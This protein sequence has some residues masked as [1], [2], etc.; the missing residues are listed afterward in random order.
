MCDFTE[1]DVVVTR[2]LQLICRHEPNLN[3]TTD[4][5]Q[6]FPHHAATYIIDGETISGIFACDLTLAEIKQLRAKQRWA[7]RDHTHDGAFAVATLSEFLDV[8]LSASRAVGIYPEV[9]HPTW[10]NSLP[11][12]L[13]AGTTIEQLVV[14]ALHARGYTAS[15]PVASDAW[16]AQPVFIQSFEPTSL[17]RLAGMTHMPLVLLMGGWE[18]YVAPDTGMTHEEMISDQFLSELAGYVAGVGPWKSSLYSVVRGSD[19]ESGNTGVSGAP[20]RSIHCSNFIHP[21]VG[22]RVDVA[23]NSSSS[24]NSSEAVV[25]QVRLRSNGLVAKLHSYGFV[26]HPYTLRDE[27]QF[28]PEGCAGQISCEF[29]WLF[30]VERVDGGFA[31]WPVTL[32]A[33]LSHRRPSGT[34]DA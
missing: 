5:W 30:E 34:A 15:S 19:S 9:K 12:L 27:P 33:W 28:V 20:C 22:R 31:D 13:A 11:Q 18:G 26:V 14:D 8:A 25:E 7:F 6:R 32:H 23:T 1:C 21:D 29:A 24:S 4:A 10:H 2:D 17:R 16:R 3:S